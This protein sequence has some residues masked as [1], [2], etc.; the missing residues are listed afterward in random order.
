MGKYIGLPEQFGHK[1]SEMFAYII[2]KV[3]A[4]T[5][6]WNQRYLSHG[7]K[8]VLLKAVVLAMPIY[9]MNVFKLPKEVCGGS[10]DLKKKKSFTGCHGRD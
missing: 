9:S 8:E 6:R 5:Q 10:K 1:K 2:E 7:G 3:R 4:V